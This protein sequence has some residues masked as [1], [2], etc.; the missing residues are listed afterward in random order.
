MSAAKRM[1]GERFL[2]VEDMP[3]VVDQ[4]V[5]L[6]DWAVQPNRR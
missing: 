3:N 2:Q 4:A 6:Y 1:I 5:A